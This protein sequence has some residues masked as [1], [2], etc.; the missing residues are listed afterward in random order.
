MAAIKQLWHS[1][2]VLVLVAGAAGTTAQT[3]PAK[4][5]RLIAS[6]APGGGY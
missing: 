3:Y 5:I 2:M 1:A 4:T 6:Q